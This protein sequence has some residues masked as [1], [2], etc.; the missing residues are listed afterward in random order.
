MAAREKVI[1][2]GLNYHDH[3][4]EQGADLPE[5]PLL[6]GKFASALIGP[7]EAI[8][9]DDGLRLVGVG[10]LDYGEI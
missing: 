9:C 8:V 3:A 2:V 10:S 4:L 6:F 5:E 1:C 7:D